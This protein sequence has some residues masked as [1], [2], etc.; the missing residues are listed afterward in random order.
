[1]HDEEHGKEVVMSAKVSSMWHARAPKGSKK[2]TYAFDDNL[3]VA[4]GDGG[5]GRSMFKVLASPVMANNLLFPVETFTPWR[6]SRP[7]GAR[8]HAKVNGQPLS[9]R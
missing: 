9:C 8:L 4:M 3:R 1:M 5:R 6:N 2:M 7:F